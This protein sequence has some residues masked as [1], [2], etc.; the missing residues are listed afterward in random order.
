MSLQAR[1]ADPGARAGG[2]CER[3]A[4]F[5]AIPGGKHLGAHPL[6]CE[7]QPRVS[8]PCQRCVTA[9]CPLCH[10]P[11]PRLPCTPCTS[12]TLPGRWWSS[13]APCADGREERE[14][15]QEILGGCTLDQNPAPTLGSCTHPGPRLCTPIETLHPLQ[16]LHPHGMLHPLPHPFPLPAPTP[17]L[18]PTPTPIPTPRPCTPAG[19][20]AHADTLRSPQVLHPHRRSIKLL[21]PLPDTYSRGGRAVE[22]WRGEWVTPSLRC[23]RSQFGPARSK[24]DPFRWASPG[25]TRTCEPRRCEGRAPHLATPLTP[26]AANG[27]A[28]RPALPEGAT[29]SPARPRRDGAAERSRAGP[30]GAEPGPSGA[31]RSRAGIQRG[32]SE[33]NRSRTGTQRRRT[34]PNRD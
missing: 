13:G 3:A 4:G 34:E 17:T 1:G 23:P 11:V 18:I 20:R 10:R 30:D 9:Q 26:R 21:L 6:P 32:R 33:P 16:V 5:R 8:P 31:G 19:P 15:I 24:L 22:R 25:G 27:S 12:C 7:C 29:P 28:P 14:E 2:G